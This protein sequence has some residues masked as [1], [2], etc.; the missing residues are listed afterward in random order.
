MSD[1]TYEGKMPTID[2]FC[3]PEPIEQ[4]EMFPGYPFFLFTEEDFSF[5]K[6]RDILKCKCAFCGKEF[7]VSKHKLQGFIKANR[8]DIVCGY[9]C[10][11]ALK[12]KK[13]KESQKH[14]D[15]YVCEECGATIQWKDKYGSG[16]FCSPF[17]YH[18]WIG[19]N[20][21]NSEESRKKKV[22]IAKIK[23][24]TLPIYI[25]NTNNSIVV[26][27]EIISKIKKMNQ[28]WLLYDIRKML[29]IDQATFK[30]IKKHCNLK[31]MPNLVPIK[32]TMLINFCRSVLNKPI[33]QG[34]ITFDD[35]ELVKQKLI[36][37]TNEER[38]SVPEILKMYGFV[39]TDHRLLTKN[40]NIQFRTHRDANIEL[41]RRK[42]YYDNLSA[43]EKYY[44]EA[45]FRFSGKLLPYV[46]GAE[47]LKTHKFCNQSNPSLN[48]IVRDHRVSRNYGFEHNIDPYLI[49]HPA[50]CELMFRDENSSKS[51]RC[52]IT[53]EQLIEEVEWWNE[54][55]IHKIFNDFK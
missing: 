26:P 54:N 38:L 4:K 29:N 34:G 50:N 9:K 35:L 22:E 11:M 8:A 42:G 53:V 27:N 36:V 20:H 40:F 10:G 16:R 25:S 12:S 37:H 19:K 1:A 2:D 30:K 17:C 46:V 55:I 15:F 31:D 48:G 18:S 13:F 32:N 21:A 24:E 43:R 5:A 44:N 3:N 52:S 39:G 14:P 7:G 51:D 33:E 41:L 23:R 45:R 6:S 49:S 47:L 28:T